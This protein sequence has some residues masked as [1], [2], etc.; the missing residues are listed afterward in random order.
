MY[1]ERVHEGYS[2]FVGDAVGE[3]DEDDVDEVLDVDDVVELVEVDEAVKKTVESAR[4]NQLGNH[5]P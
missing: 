2:Q 5:V 1:D 4:R 3:L